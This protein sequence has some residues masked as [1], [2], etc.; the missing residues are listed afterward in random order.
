MEHGAA[1]RVAGPGARLLEEVAQ[2]AEALEAAGLGTLVLEGDRDAAFGSWD[3]YLVLQAIARATSRVRLTTGGDLLALRS[4]GVRAKQVASL[5]WFAGGRLDYSVDIDP[6]PAA[7]RDP[8]LPEDPDELATAL[9]HLEAMT[10]LW[11]QDRAEHHGERI[12]F[13]GAIALPKPSRGR[14]TVLVRSQ[15]PER[16]RAWTAGGGAVDGLLLAGVGADRVASLVHAAGSAPSR[17]VWVVPA[18]TVT[19]VRDLAPDLGVTELVAHF[20]HL[21]TPDDLARLSDALV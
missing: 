7:L 14:P 8:F 1:V 6:A 16:L 12:D 3:P 4:A 10:A 5:D 15:D 11:T 9:E 2:S 20:D 19:Q 21:P 13:E 17:V 18:D